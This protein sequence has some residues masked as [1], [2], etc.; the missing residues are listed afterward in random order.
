MNAISPRYRDFDFC[1]SSCSLE[2]LGSIEA[3]LNFIK[4]SI[5]TLKVGGVAVHTTEYNVSSNRRLSTTIPPWSCSGVATFS[6]SS[7]SYRAKAISLRRFALTFLREPIDL[8]VDI[9]PYVADLIIRLVLS[10]FVASS[11]GLVIQRGR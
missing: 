7:Q 5:N 3:G 4:A 2:R 6:V 9:P 11:I 10:N 8:F 1:W